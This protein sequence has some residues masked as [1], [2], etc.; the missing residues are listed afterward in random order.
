MEIPTVA[1]PVY[2]PI[3]NLIQEMKEHGNVSEDK[4]EAIMTYQKEWL[5]QVDLL[6][7]N[8]KAEAVKVKEYLG[9]DCPPQEIMYNAV[10]MQETLHMD[11]LAADGP[12]KVGLDG[13]GDYVACIGTLQ[14]RKGQERLV[15]AM[16]ALKREY[17]EAKLL[18]A[19]EVDEGYINDFKPYMDDSME[20][21]PRK[22]D[23]AEVR[24]II[25]NA[26]VV[27]QPSVFETPGLVLLEAAS[28]G[29]PIV[30][31]ENGSTGEYFNDDAHYCNPFRVDSI[32]EALISAWEDSPNKEL[33]NKVRST[34]NYSQ[35]A[36]K[37]EEIYKSLVEEG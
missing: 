33:K 23:P 17:P 25:A 4:F 22:L 34:Y 2:W 37:A 1:T 13:M 8:S 15:H 19:G 6:L 3:K 26:K 30:A 28:I 16:Q 36:K 31:T 32:G 5:T 14:P 10:N 24:A 12:E 18:M 29:K 9:G 11:S 35:S 20:L 7:T 27:A 21:I